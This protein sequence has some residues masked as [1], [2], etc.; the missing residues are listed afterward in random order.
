MEGANIIQKLVDIAVE[1]YHSLMLPRVVGKGI[2]SQRHLHDP[3]AGDDHE[4]QMTPTPSVGTVD[5]DSHQ[6]HHFGTQPSQ[7]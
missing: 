3:Q 1:L 5:Y 2:Y 4:L 7:T 6:T